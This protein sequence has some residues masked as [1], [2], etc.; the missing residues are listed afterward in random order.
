MAKKKLQSGF[1]LPGISP[2]ILLK[3]IENTIPFLFK[4]EI[5]TKASK[6]EF[7]DKIRFYK[8][9][10]KQLNHINH[11]EYYHLCIC[12]HWATAGS[13]VPTDVDNQIREGLWRHPKALKNLEKM[14]DLTI[15][16]LTWDYG[17]VTKRVC[18]ALSTHEGTWFSVA[19]GAYCSLKQ[20]NYLDKAKEVADSILKEIHSEI[21]ILKEL[22]KN[23]DHISFIK[24]APLIAHN[25]GDLDRVMVVWNM[26]DTDEFCQSIYKLGHRVTSDFSP[27]LVFA[28][29]VN[30]QFTANENH[31]HMALRQPKCLRKSKDFLVH[32]GP[33]MDHWG[34]IIG[35]SS[36]LSYIE[37]A[38]IITA[39]Y[40][41][42]KREKEAIGY[43]RALG[44]VLNYSENNLN[45]YEEF[46][47]YDLV[48]ELKNSVFFKDS[49]LAKD[50]FENSYI[51]KLNAFICPITNL[52]F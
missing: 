32:V 38:E 39:L 35:Q 52:R 29:Q 28:G 27:L 42:F 21:S 48:K 24:A 8:K 5:D 18:G 44:G 3:H 13:F 16:A 40:E 33:F 49:M 1:E 4:N 37:K 9:N 12:A 51:E 25:F 43:A 34:Q 47:P 31:R 23:R 50:D 2:N 45:E 22:Q 6:R 30:K 41:G 19:I 26:H 14:A 11:F 15:D 36:K 10:L 17:Q 46:L 20:N 7:L